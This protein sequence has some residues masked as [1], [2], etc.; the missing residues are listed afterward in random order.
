[1]HMPA[2]TSHLLATCVC[3]LSVCLG[4]CVCQTNYGGSDC[5]V[6]TN[7]PPN[8]FQLSNGGFCDLR[9]NSCKEVIIYNNNTVHVEDLSCFITEVKVSSVVILF[10][11]FQCLVWLEYNLKLSAMSDFTCHWH[12]FSVWPLLEYDSW[13][14]CLYGYFFVIAD[15]N[16]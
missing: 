9:E 15:S 12:S 14:I 16:N 2:R 3:A 8:L 7:E 4:V 11:L 6:K 1:M 13:P 10:A 5:F